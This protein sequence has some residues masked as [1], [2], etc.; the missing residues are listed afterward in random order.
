[1][2]GKYCPP[3]TEE[4]KSGKKGSKPPVAIKTKKGGKK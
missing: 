2:A 1:M 3:G 4:K